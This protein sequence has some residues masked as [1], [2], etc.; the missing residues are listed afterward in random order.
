MPLELLNEICKLKKYKINEKTVLA[1]SVEE[2][3]ELLNRNNDKVYLIKE[4]HELTLAD[5]DLSTINR[6]VKEYQMELGGF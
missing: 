6:L 3:K 4:S 5:L 1:R 2:A